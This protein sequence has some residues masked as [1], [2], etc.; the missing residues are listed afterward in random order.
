MTGY[1]RR[2]TWKKKCIMF[3]QVQLR[4]MDDVISRGI[5]SLLLFKVVHAGFL[6]AIWNNR[7]T[8]SQN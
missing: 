6:L 8:L 4:N 5:A 2:L 1:P 7:F 3:P